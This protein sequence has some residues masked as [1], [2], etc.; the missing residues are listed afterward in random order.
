MTD[1]VID[2]D[3][4]RERL[5]DL[6]TEEVT[7][8]VVVQCGQDWLLPELTAFRNEVDQALMT[9]QLRRGD[10]LAITR[11]VLHSL[12]LEPNTAARPTAIDE[13]FEE[14]HHRLSA[15]SV[16]LCDSSPAAP[17][18]H[19]L[20]LRG[21]QVA[22]DVPDMLE[23]RKNGEWTDPHMAGLALRTTEIVGATTPLTG[24][25]LSLDGPFGDADP[26][27]YM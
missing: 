19:R 10:S 25:D 27:V 5:A 8:A 17:R 24:Y 15:T 11:V 13:A 7:A 4:W 20:I 14:W 23:L 3:A 2:A 22:A 21:D 16:L 18:V 6:G 9:A 26:S 1:P 12:P